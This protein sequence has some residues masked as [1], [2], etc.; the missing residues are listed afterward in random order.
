MRGLPSQFA[1]ENGEFFVRTYL[2]ER[3]PTG[4]YHFTAKGAD[5]G[6]LTITD[7]TLDGGSPNVTAEP[8]TTEA[9]PIVT[10][11]NSDG[12]TVGPATDQSPLQVQDPQ[13]EPSF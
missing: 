9:A 8:A 12:G 11:S 2:D 4:L 3:L 7:L 10:D 13:P 5:T 1:N 6:R